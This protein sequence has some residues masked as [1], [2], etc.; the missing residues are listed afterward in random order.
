MRAEHVFPKIYTAE[1][2]IAYIPWYYELHNARYDMVQYKE[3]RIDQ[4]CPRDGNRLDVVPIS[5]TT[6]CRCPEEAD[7]CCHSLDTGH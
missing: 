4:H 6:P 5:G 1:L 7:F 3:P 2:L